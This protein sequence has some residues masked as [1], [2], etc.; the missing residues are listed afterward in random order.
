MMAMQKIDNRPNLKY[1]MQGLISNEIMIDLPISGLC[2][3]SRKVMD[4]DIFIALNG[5]HKNGMNFIKDAINKGAVAV[6]IG[7]ELEGV[8]NFLSI[9]I[10]SIINLD[11]KLGLLAS[12]YYNNPSQNLNII[13]VTGTNGK[14]SVASFLAQILSKHGQMPV[15]SI[16]TLG[17][18]I[19]GN[20]KPS[21]NTTPDILTINRLLAEFSSHHIKDVVM[22]V[23]SHGLEQG[24]VDNLIFETA[25][26]TNLSRD[27]LDFH[28]DMSLYGAAKEKLFDKPGLKNAV[29]NID[30]EFGIKLASKI[31]YHINKIRYGLL[32]NH[33]KRNSNVHDVTAKIVRS[34]LNSITIDISSPWGKGEVAVS[35]SGDFNVNNVLAC[36]SVVCLQGMTFDNALEAISKIQGVPGRMEYFGKPSTAKIFIDYSHTPDALLHAL[37]TLRSQCKERLVCVFGCGGDRDI[38][39]RPQ[40]GHIAEQYADLVF[41]TNDNPR[42]ESPE[43]I[44]KDI[45]SGMKGSVPVEVIVDRSS[46]I[47]EAIHTSGKDDY[48]LIAGKGHEIYQEIG[49]V[50]HPYSDRQ[51]VRNLLEK[52]S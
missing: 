30:D 2:L 13:G 36:L 46:A 24:R 32:D 26:F 20:L 37:E 12:R 33:K 5:T 6:L 41:L 52:L 51:Q 22:E 48:V 9:P 10:F 21:P 8:T 42:S 45:Q 4:G 35:L 23:S 16:G 31:S 18:G 40:M 14:T 49:L 50:K 28:G 43:K 34:E 19:F 11:S 3:D 27:H 17:S 47:R 29:I 1:L 39:K 15:G 25:V 38:G 44:I 7:S